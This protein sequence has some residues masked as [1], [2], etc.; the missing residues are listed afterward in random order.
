[1][2]EEGTAQEGNTTTPETE[3]VEQPDAPKPT[4]TVEFWKQKAR[5]QERK[6]KDNAQAAK[7]LDDLKAAQL[8]NEERIAAERDKAIAERDNA[9]TELLRWKVATKFGIADED[10]DLFLTGTDE[11]TLLKQAERLAERTAASKPS[12]NGLHVPVEGRTPSVPALNSDDLEG[13][14]RRKLGIN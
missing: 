14:L 8:S 5:E 11:D 1:M 9:M 4:E 6:A 2:A 3:V 12:K 10:V 7:E 13:A